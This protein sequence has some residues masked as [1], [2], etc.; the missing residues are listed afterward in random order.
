MGDAALVGV[1][2]AVGAAGAAVVDAAVVGAAAVGAAVL[3]MARGVTV[4]PGPAAAAVRPPFGRVTV[5]I[6]TPVACQSISAASTGATTIAAAP[7]IFFVSVS[8]RCA[9]VGGGAAAGGGPSSSSRVQRG[10]QR[11]GLFGRL[12]LIGRPPDTPLARVVNE[13]NGAAD[14]ELR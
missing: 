7:A 11:V 10:S 8:A 13:K 9:V 5:S 6:T 4:A 14:T 3:Q 2:T 1:V 12:C